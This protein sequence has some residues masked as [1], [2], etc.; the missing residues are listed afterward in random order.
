MKM[1]M[2]GACLAFALLLGS[3]GCVTAP[4]FDYTS[5]IESDPHSILIVPVM[6]NS[7]EV[8]ADAWFL[9]TISVPLAE[10]GYYVFPVNMTREMLANAGLSDAG[11][12]REA[13]PTLIAKLMGADAVLFVKIT[14]WEA[15]YLI[16]AT[17]VKVG[18]EYVLKDGKTGQEIWSTKQLMTYTPQSTSSGNAIADLIVM[19]V[20]AAATKAAPNYIPL[21][22]QANQSIATGKNAANPGFTISSPLLPGPYHPSYASD[23]QNRALAAKSATAAKPANKR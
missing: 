15:Q 3:I 22:R 16:F 2:I 18:F 1:N 20:Q 6:N 8:G 12:L 4:K 10:R 7:P 21:A 9:A 19:A 17:T 11:L 5:Y 13:D 14:N 23:R